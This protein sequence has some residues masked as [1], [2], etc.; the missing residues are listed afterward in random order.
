[1]TA[2]ARPIECQRWALRRG[3]VLFTKDSETPEEIGIPAYVT[4]DMPTVL[5]GYHLGMAR[6]RDNLVDGAYL[7]ET[8]GSPTSGKQFARIA[9]GVTRFGLTLAATR[10]LPILLPP[11]S[12]QRAIAAVLNSIDEAIERTEAVIATTER[13]RDALLHE[14]LTRGV[15]GWHSEWK[16]APG[17]GTIPACWDVVPLGD[18]LVLDQP[19]SW[20]DDPTPGNPGVPVLRAT[21]LTRDGRVD[22]SQAALRRLSERDQENRRLI[23]GDLILER[24]GGGPGTP[25]GRVAVVDGLGS[26]YCNN[27]CQQLR[28]DDARCSPYYAARALWRRYLQGV[29]SRLEHRTTGIRNL[30]YSGYLLFPIPLP[31]LDEQGSIVD[32]LDAVDQT[33]GHANEELKALQL[34]KASTSDALLAGRVRTAIGST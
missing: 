16:E 10:S 25:V 15:P 23:D 20:G 34:L 18:I 33:I 24:S 19:G 29:T 30:D 6:P 26:V 13:L 5:C 22:P 32:S 11:L 21:D 12:E 27:F 8:L 3:D 4:E 28:V 31:T 1:M 2:T 17:I 9:N 7:S 14:L